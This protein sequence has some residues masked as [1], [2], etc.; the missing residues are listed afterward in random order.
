MQRR[1]GAEGEN[2]DARAPSS[3]HP[4]VVGQFKSDSY[5][6]DLNMSADPIA[7]SQNFMGPQ[8]SANAQTLGC[9]GSLPH[10]F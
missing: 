8:L 6:R 5:S 3:D 9:L 7:A 2:K 1:I 10:L 4:A